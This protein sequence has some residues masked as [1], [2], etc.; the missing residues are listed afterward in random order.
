MILLFK[1]GFLELSYIDIA[2]IMLLT[3]FFYQLYKLMRGTVALK[4]FIGSLGIYLAYLVFR[5]LEMKLLTAIF[6]KVIGVGVIAIIVLFQPE[7]RRFLLMLGRSSMLDKGFSWKF[8]PMKSSYY[9]ITPIVESVKN[10]AATNTGAL[11]VCTRTSDLRYY[12]ETGEILEANLSKKLLIS[13]FNKYSPL[14]DGAV[15][16]SEGKIKAARC[17]LPV[18]ESDDIPTQLGLRHRSALGITE[19]SDCVVVVTSEESGSISFADHGQL[20][21]DIPQNEIHARLSKLLFPSG[22]SLLKPVS[23]INAKFQFS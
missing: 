7:I 4:I 12:V 18:S 20:Y 15:I 10:L 9:D 22:D 11:I 21:Y 13:I 6:G 2:E 8:L 1:I 17:I 5:A 3:F 19:H 16:V 23:K 14:H